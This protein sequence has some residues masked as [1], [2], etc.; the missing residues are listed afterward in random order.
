MQPR[1]ALTARP[2]GAPGGALLPP[3]LVCHGCR[4]IPQFRGAPR[5]SQGRPKHEPQGSRPVLRP[6][7]TER[8]P[9]RRK[10]SPGSSSSDHCTPQDSQH[11]PEDL[12]SESPPKTPD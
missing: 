12:T 10:R 5:L 7:V 2:P 1:S 4:R 9:R 8:C 6:S 3:S 11:R